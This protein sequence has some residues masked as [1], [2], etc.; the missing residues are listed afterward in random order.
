MIF[1][2]Y[3]IYNIFCFLTRVFKKIFKIWFLLIFFP[4]GFGGELVQIWSTY[5]NTFKL[6]YE[7]FFWGFSSYK[8]AIN[9]IPY[10]FLLIFFPL[11]FKGV[12][13]EYQHIYV[14]SIF[15]PIFPKGLR[16]FSHDIYIQLLIFPMGFLGSFLID[17]RTTRRTN[18]SRGSVMKQIN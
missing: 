3:Y 7:F 5:H 1:E 15:S 2:T 11:S 17:Y 13:M 18:W 8:F 6:T 10:H 16:S 12:L 9:D 4:S 14:I